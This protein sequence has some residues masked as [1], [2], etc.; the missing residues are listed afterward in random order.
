MN[1][2]HY[3]QPTSLGEAVDLLARYGAQAR[4]HAGGS[5]L[6][7]DIQRGELQPQHLIGLDSVPGLNDIV[8][9]EEGEITIGAMITLTDLARYAGDRLELR[10]I[11][12]AV[13]LLAGRQVQNVA[14]VGGNICNASPGA[15]MVPSLLCLDAQLRLQSPDGERLVPLDGFI[16]APN[17]AELRPGE[18]LTA[19]V[20][21]TLPPHS[22]SAT[23]KIMRRRA[24]DLS[25]AAVSARITLSE[26]GQRCAQARIALCAVAPTPIRVRSAEELLTGV[27][28]TP[29]RVIAAAR[30]AAAEA[31]PVDDVRASAEYRR[32]VLVTLV[33]R[34]VNLAAQRALS[35]SKE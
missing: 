12:E 35:A 4:I 9:S 6:L 7:V 16:I 2:F 20:L 5:A 24:K 26:D 10:A 27:A 32:M 29:E 11:V 1:P 28:L 19:I 33:E 30:A 3:H 15:D 25:I 8:E 34:A 17:R 18:I 22:A 21:P 23:Q 14:T 31:R 13:Q